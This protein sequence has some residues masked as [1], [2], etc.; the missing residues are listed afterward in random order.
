MG[1]VD[2]DAGDRIPWAL[3]PELPYKEERDP[4]VRANGMGLPR[5]VRAPSKPRFL[6]ISLAISI[7]QFPQLSLRGA[8]ADA[9]VQSPSV[10]AALAR[11]SR[12]GCVTRRAH[13]FLTGAMRAKTDPER[14]P[15]ICE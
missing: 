4:A 2:S 6:A 14:L 15:R 11:F 10:A 3:R 9:P 12:P 7:V 5:D 13:N 1:S 8:V